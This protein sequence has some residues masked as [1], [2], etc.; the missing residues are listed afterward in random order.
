M[1]LIVIAHHADA[2]GV[3]VIT[4]DQ[5]ALATHLSRAKV[6]A[7][8]ATLDTR[9]IIERKAGGRST[10]ALVDYDPQAGWAKLP[11]RELYSKGM[12]PAFADFKLRSAA[13]LNAL[14]LYLL[15]VARRGNDT[16]MANIS[17]DKISEYT[18]VDRNRIKQALSVLAVA[19]L[20]HA[21]RVPSEFHESG[22]ANAYRITHLDPYAHMGTRGRAMDE[23]AF[24]LA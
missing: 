15:F 13:E 8:L 7:G 10:F 9:G 1:L 11:A 17:Y 20:A 3:S 21:E 14:K 5:L 4:Y 2:E 6:S 18:G 22:V 24:D 16:N 19:G 23:G 12:I